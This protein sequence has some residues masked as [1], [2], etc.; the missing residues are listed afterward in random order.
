MNI[1]NV[2]LENKYIMAPMAGVTDLPFRLLCKEQG[3]ALT[4]T[5][6][7]SAKALYYEDKKTKKLLATKPEEGSVGIQLFGK[8]PKIISQVIKHAIN[9]LP[10]DLIDLNCGCP[11]PKITK[12]GEGAALLKEPHL[13]GEIIYQMV[14]VSYKPVTLKIRCGWDEKNMNAIEVAKIAEDAGAR[15]ITVHARTREQFY[16]GK[17]NWKVIQEVKNSVNIPVV[18][19]GDVKNYNDA[20]SLFKMTHCDGIMIGRSA[21]GNPW[22]FQELITGRSQN[23]DIINRIDTIIRQLTSMLTIKPEYIVVGEIR[24]HIAWYTKGLNNSSELRNRINKIVDLED[25]ILTLRK[26][27]ED[28]RI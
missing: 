6:M 10:F 17:S 22:I 3:C 11:A 5:E 21:L 7:I 1:G 16:S 13:I 18:G 4:F 24:K 23:I 9:Y 27:A 25:I 19:N 20:K 15:A 28:Y 14:K 2:S 26:F 8:E 12:N